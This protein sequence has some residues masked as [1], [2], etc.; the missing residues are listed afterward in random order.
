MNFFI[1]HVKGI[2]QTVKY[3]RCVIAKSVNHDTNGKI[4]NVNFF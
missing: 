1:I 3:N 4:C 2:Y